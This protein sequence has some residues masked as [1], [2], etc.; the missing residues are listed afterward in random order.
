MDF[1]NLAILDRRSEKSVVTIAIG[2][3]QAIEDL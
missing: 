1:L 2:Y 3:S